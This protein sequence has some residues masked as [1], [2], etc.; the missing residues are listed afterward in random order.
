MT[1]RRRPL[2]FLRTVLGSLCAT[3]L[4][5]LL[6]AVLWGVVSRYLLGGQARWTEESARMLLVWLTFAGAAL[7]FGHRAHLG[8]DA[9]VMRFDP[10]VRRFSAGLAQVLVLIFAGYLLVYGG[11]RLCLETFALGQMLI[12][13][14]VAK[15]WIYLSVPFAGICIAAFAI[16]EMIL[17]HPESKEEID[18]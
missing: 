12:T 4:A 2:D 11:G 5:V 7:A 8:L 17:P 14:P 16:E 13:L 9:L 15:G 6:L 18:G 3:L 1:A 10:A